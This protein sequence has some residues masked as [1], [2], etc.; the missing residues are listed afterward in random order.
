[1]AT[2]NPIEDRRTLLAFVANVVAAAASRQDDEY[3]N[4][5]VSSPMAMWIYD[6]ESL[7]ILDANEAAQQRYGYSRDEFTRLTLTDIR[8]REDVSKFLELTR[9]LPDF[10]R[11]GPWRHR[12]KD[13]SVV[14]VLINSHAVRIGPREARLVI[15]EDPDSAPI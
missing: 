10:D 9:T 11:S 13:G 12:R 7:Q 4:V 2:N 6:V 15:V 8:P 3:V 5:F 14:Q 1:M